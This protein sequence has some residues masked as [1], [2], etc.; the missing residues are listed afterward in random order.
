[1]PVSQIL[2]NST[3]LTTQINVQILSKNF[4][5]SDY[6]SNWLVK[7][8]LNPISVPGLSYLS[9]HNIMCGRRS[10]NL[11]KLS[12]KYDFI[13]GLVNG[14]FPFL[15]SFKLN[16]FL[17][18]Y[19]I[20]NPYQLDSIFIDFYRRWTIKEA[21]KIFIGVW[22]KSACSNIIRCSVASVFYLFHQRVFWLIASSLE[23]RVQ[24][25]NVG[26]NMPL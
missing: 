5:D 7:F 8:I 17:L 10:V 23:Y 15:C 21:I 6:V 13:I 22:F 19:W 20:V 9:P 11:N 24:V 2:W 25:S 26:S 12:C 18:F 16:S 4:E 3:R 1:M 14:I